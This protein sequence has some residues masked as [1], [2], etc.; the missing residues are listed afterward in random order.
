MFGQQ[1]SLITVTKSVMPHAP[2]RPLDGWERAGCGG[3]IRGEKGGWDEKQVLA[4]TTLTSAETDMSAGEDTGSRTTSKF[5]HA[6]LCSTKAQKTDQGS[7]SVVY[8]SV[9]PK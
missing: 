5:C 8:Y 1:R 9:W 7:G 4:A 3:G 6:C 2:G